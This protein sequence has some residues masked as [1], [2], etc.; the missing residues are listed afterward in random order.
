LQECRQY[1]IKLVVIDS[2]GLALEGDSEA[3]RDVIRFH[4][5]FIEPFR[6]EGVA[7]VM[8]D[9][10][11]KQQGGQRYRDKTAFGSVYKSNLARSVVQ[12][13]P[14]EREDGMLIVKLQQKKH[15][16][17]QLFDPVGA[18]LTFSEQS[19]TVEAVRLDRGDFEEGKE[20]N[21]TEKVRRALGNGPAYP[22]EL[23]K[24]TGLALKTVQNVLTRLKKRG[25]VETTGA[26]RGQSEQ[27]RLVSPSP[28]P[29]RDGDGD[30]D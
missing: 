28:S 15:N 22:D 11:S 5:E 3:A 1:G 27:V 8:V 13:E 7:V 23:A 10:Q 29:I 9:H 2:V 19:V 18:K 6:A 21:A 30:T 26:R 12:A 4:N 16:F 20:P 25:E 17:G 24:S 14:I